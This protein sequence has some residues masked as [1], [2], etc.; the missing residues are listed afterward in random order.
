MDADEMSQRY[1]NLIE[2][3][4]GE[5]LQKWG[6][7]LAEQLGTGK[8][9]A[10]YVL[11]FGSM[12]GQNEAEA[13]AR[14]YDYGNLADISMI[15]ERWRDLNVISEAIDGEL[16]YKGQYDTDFQKAFGKTIAEALFSDIGEGDLAELEVPGSTF[17]GMGG[18]NPDLIGVKPRQ[19]QGLY[20]AIRRQFGEDLTDEQITQILNSGG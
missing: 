9:G 1:R 17:L 19:T 3:P 13:R 8:N 11:E 14:G 10:S 2:G 4:A 7:D 16:W 5:Q 18:E 6:A 15:W 12:L 20:D